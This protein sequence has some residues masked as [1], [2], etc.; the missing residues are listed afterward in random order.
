MKH[1][2]SSKKRP[3]THFSCLFL[4]LPVLLLCMPR[5]TSAQAG[6]TV[7]QGVVKD[8]EAGMALPN[9]TL[10]LLKDSSAIMA[11]VTDTTGA[12]KTKPLLPG[13][14]RLVLSYMGYRSLDTLIAVKA[15]IPAIHLGIL[16]LKA[17]GITLK[18]V[19]IADQPPPVNIS[20]DTVE[21]NA[22]AFKIHEN[23]VA[24]DLLK[25]LPGI[26]VDKDGNITANGE[27]VQQILVDGKPFFGNDPK[28][29]TK[30]LPS[31]IIAKI[32]VFDKT[33]DQA[34]FTGI[35]DGNTK[36][37]INIVIKK[38]RRKGTFGR[39][40]A[41]Y[42]SND[43]YQFSGMLNRFDNDRRV[44]V[45]AGANNV[46][47]SGF[48]YRD[49]SGGGNTNDGITATRMGG[50]NYR[51]NWGK[52]TEV[53]GSY[54][55]SS[56]NNES[57]QKS[58]RENILL[59]SSFF[60]RQESAATSRSLNHRLNFNVEHKIDS[61]KSVIFRTGANYTTS[62]N[63]SENN[64]A[65]FSDK[66]SPINSSS[67]A[68]RAHNASPDMDASL[69]YRQ[70]MKKKGRT[71]SLGLSASVDHNNGYSYNRSLNHFYTPEDSSVLLDQK[72]TTDS[73]TTNWGI[74]VSYTEPL[75]TGHYLELEYAMDRRSAA[76]DRFTNNLDPV[77]GQY[78]LFD[79]LYSNSF[80][81]PNAK[82]RGSVNFIANKEKYEYTVGLSL[83]QSAL[84]SEWV[85]TG[86]T[87][88][89]RALN[90]YPLLNFRYNFSKTRR[91]KV[92]YRGSTQQ[93]SIAQLQPVPDNTN[94]L[95]IRLGNPD[96][97]NSFSNSVRVNYNATNPVTYQSFQAAL[98]FSAVANQI[99]TSSYYDAQ[100]KQYTMPVNINGTY[101]VNGNLAFSF[102]LRHPDLKFNPGT[103]LAFNHG[104]G[105]VNNEK[106][107]SDNLTLGQRLGMSYAKEGLV[108]MDVSGRVNYNKVNYSL[109]ASQNQEYFTYNFSVDME[110]RLPAGFLLGSDFRYTANSGLAKGYNRK[111][112]I[113]NAYF[114][115]QFF[116][117]KQA[118]LKLQCYDLL[119]QQLSIQREIGAT[120]VQDTE[121]MVLARYLLL[122]FTYNFNRFGGGAARRGGKPSDKERPARESARK[123]QKSEGRGN[124]GGGRGRRGF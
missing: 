43:R 50:V 88:T 96:L 36:K 13:N 99:V 34:A 46:N 58:N 59:D 24:E 111:I 52:K 10:T 47:S 65:A 26:E 6:G 80:R 90:F 95:R 69:L 109:Q 75:F 44:S 68:A 102:P 25:K 81:N 105:F 86:K 84:S 64:S 3:A 97:K 121:S 54:F 89:Q 18:G 82:D 17:T 30:N 119:N 74:S 1:N 19:L 98:N 101:N 61:M 12:F 29:A 11:T 115:K 2:R 93:P 9:A 14:Y 8:R 118:M 51:D 123:G 7:L 120:Y 55:V 48:T 122:T 71:F 49:I 16:Y 107:F 94:T 40:T 66:D 108:D 53:N 35:H 78:D 112:S 91:L 83:Q 85:M 103:A 32:Q 23:A 114:G 42:G 4:L 87:V 33:S 28:I 106:N 15:G 60:S 41:G 124:G 77:T 62:D 22:G 67:R 21:F 20:G 45:L 100:R 104:L 39:G 57:A 117:K 37:A 73:Y 92:E 76:S 113:W 70:K 110:W 31:D 56:T 5:R 79:S 38:D 63:S 27:A 116:E 72:K